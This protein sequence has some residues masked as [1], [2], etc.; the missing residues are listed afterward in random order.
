MSHELAIT[1][2]S[3]HAHNVYPTLAHQYLV[4]SSFV[5]PI[6]IGCIFVEKGKLIPVGTSRTG[7]LMKWL[8]ILYQ[9][10]LL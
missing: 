4:S 1:Q 2:L 5:L 10:T 7:T 6:Q 9:N 8:T 3:R